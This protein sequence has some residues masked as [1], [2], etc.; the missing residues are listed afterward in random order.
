MK[1]SAWT[2]VHSSNPEKADNNWWHYTFTLYNDEKDLRRCP[3]IYQHKLHF[4]ELHINNFHLQ[5]MRV[6]IL[7]SLYTWFCSVYACKLCYHWRTAFAHFVLPILPKFCTMSSEKSLLFFSSLHFFHAL[8]ISLSLFRIK[9][10][11]KPSDQCSFLSLRWEMPG[12]HKMKKREADLSL[13]H[14]S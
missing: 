6:V 2:D 8:V 1:E 13:I 9:E 10:K 11:E 4:T 5:V 14:R 12:P 3:I 7:L